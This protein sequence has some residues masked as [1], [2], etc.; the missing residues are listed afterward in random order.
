MTPRASVVVPTFNRPDLLDRCLQALVCQ[1]IGPGCFEVIVVDDAASESTCRQVECWT[2][3]AHQRGIVVRYVPT[4]GKCGPAAARNAGWH[5]ARG[6]IIAF[7]DDDCIPQPGW[8]AAGLS[9]FT[10]GV[11]AV[12]GRLVMPLPAQP[13]D[14][15]KNAAGLEVA[16][17]VTANCFYRRDILEAVGG[18]DERFR[19]AWRE[20]SDL[21]FR[22]LDLGQ[23]IGYS[24]GAI[25]VHPVR[26]G[27]WGVS[28]SQQRK[29][30][31]N[32]LLYRKHP[33]RY[34]E[35]VQASPPWR[36]YRIIAALAT[37]L[38]AG[39]LG[40]KRTALAAAAAW[41]V[42]TGG[43]CAERLDG[44]SRAPAHI[45]EMLVTSAVIPPLAVYWRIRGAIRYRVLFL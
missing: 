20:D 37:A 8:L 25:V 16:E 23:R 3:P 31:Y 24:P 32:A 5:V 15:E 10:D 17:F 7:T 27:G 22:V 29:S 34:R 18:F 42:M 39:M 9:V 6:E 40:Q 14:Y 26:P 36:Y 1:E 2:R 28:I 44:T 41:V 45:A 33:V 21:F 13:T 11:A 43:F 30:V 12:D 38:G 4:R 19:A 35:R